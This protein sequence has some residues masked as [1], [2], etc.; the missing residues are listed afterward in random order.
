MRTAFTIRALPLT[1]LQRSRGQVFTFAAK[2][3]GEDARSG[4]E[5]SDSGRRFRRLW[6]NGKASAHLCSVDSDMFVMTSA[7]IMRPHHRYIS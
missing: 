2:S 3:E 7:A 5:H 6:P 4:L 1:L